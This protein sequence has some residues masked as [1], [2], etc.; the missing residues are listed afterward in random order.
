[1]LKK[2]L[3]HFM[4]K[5]YKKQINKD[6]GKEKEI[7]YMSSGKDMIIHLRVG[8]IKTS[9]YFLKPYEPFGGNINVKVDLSNN[10][11]KGNIKNISHV[12]I[13]SLVL[14]S[15]LASLK[16]ENNNLDIGKLVPAPV[17][18]SKLN[19]LVKIILLRKLCMKN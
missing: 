6:F 18:L 15:N 3:E 7:S 13:S 10:A 2:L 9:Q 14:K 17:D 12:D 19:D 8:S 11:T 4:K 16:T 1:M 5:N